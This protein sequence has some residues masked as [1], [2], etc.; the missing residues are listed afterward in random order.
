MLIEETVKAHLD[1][2]FENTGVG[3]YLETPEVLP[4]KFIVF[5]LIDRG[6]ENRINEVTLDFRSYAQS[7]YD[8]AMLDDTLRG[9]MDALNDGTDITCHLGGGN[10]DTD[11]VLKK[12]RYRCYYNLY[13]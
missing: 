3:V 9:A 7:K 6:I 2:V 13:Y 4:D 10:D 5:Q 1:T 8:A 11:S 12:Y